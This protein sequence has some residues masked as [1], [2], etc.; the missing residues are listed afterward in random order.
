MYDQRAKGQTLER[1]KEV[2]CYSDETPKIEHSNWLCSTCQK[3]IP[4]LKV[5]TVRMADLVNRLK[6]ESELKDTF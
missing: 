4:Q 1:G 5:R 6:S 2:T 3:Y